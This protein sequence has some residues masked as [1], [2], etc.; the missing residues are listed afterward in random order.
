MNIMSQ[1]CRKRKKYSYQVKQIKA[2]H[3][4]FRK[5]HN[6]FMIKRQRC[7]RSVACENHYT[8][9]MLLKLTHLQSNRTEFG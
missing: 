7:S 2:C 6:F 1:I 5:V 4:C 9:V 3:V 8:H